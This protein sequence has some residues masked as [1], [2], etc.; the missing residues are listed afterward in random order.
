VADQMEPNGPGE[1]DRPNTGDLPTTSGEAK[2]TTTIDEEGVPQIKV[3]YLHDT[4]TPRWITITA[5]ITKASL[6]VAA[7]LGIA[8]MILALWSMTRDRDQV[9]NELSCRSASAVVVDQATAIELANIG[10]GITLINEG[11]IA[12]ADPDGHP[13]G[14]NLIERAI[15]NGSELERSA[16][17]LIEAVNARETSLDVCAEGGTAVETSTTPTVAT[18]EQEP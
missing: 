15:A 18:T 2:V 16:R 9:R 5:A 3:Q 10:R 12:V 7:V 4:P 11:L 13:A 17:E 1:V 14:A 6:G 8:G